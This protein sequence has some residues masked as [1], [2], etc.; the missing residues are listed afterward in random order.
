LKCDFAVR[1]ELS[2]LRRAC[3]FLSIAMVAGVPPAT[4]DEATELL[5]SAY[6]LK[7]RG[8][9][10]GA[11]DAFIEARRAGAAPQRI[12]LELAYVYL[13]LG[14][15]AAARFELDAAAAGPDAVLARAARRQLD[16]LPSTWWA[17]V[18]AESYGWTRLRG[19]TDST[20]LVPTIRVRGLRRLA[21][22]ADLHAYVFAQATRDLA[23]RGFGAAIP[24]I[25]ADN[26]ALTGGGMLLR[27]A[28]RHVGLFAQVGPAI[29]L[30][31][32]GHDAVELDVRGGAFLA[33]AS[34]AC[35]EQ[36]GIIENETW[37]AELYGE[38]VYTSRF[39]HD[40]QGFAR[41]RTSFTYVETGPVSWQFFGEL[42]A[43]FDRNGDFYDNFL[44]AGIG[45]RWRLRRPIAID[46]QIGGH[47]GAY[48]GRENRDPAPMQQDYLDLRAFATTYVELD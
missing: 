42:R 1:F 5:A 2:S 3:L 19:E 28:N 35:F 47:V 40:V 39:D 21:D 22:R 33:L 25:Y 17:D 31:D 36:G 12:A 44:D 4:A 43:A 24:A 37:C 8:D 6:D 11:I 23:S 20:D 10:D 48:L 18:Y 45:P 14:Q 9:R 13:S 38:A 30:I 15:T 29:T 46:L 7:A 41:Q 32:D 27:L 16:E 34:A 26:R